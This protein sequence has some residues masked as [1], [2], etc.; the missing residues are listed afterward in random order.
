MNQ[1][2]GFVWVLVI[3]FRKKIVHSSIFHKAK[4]KQ[5]SNHINLFYLEKEYSFGNVV[6]K[7]SRDYYCSFMEGFYYSSKKE[8][9]KK[10]KY[11]SVLK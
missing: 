9:K 4:T 11:E 5:K 1:E 2:L 3:I 7:I 10:L 8:R 6:M